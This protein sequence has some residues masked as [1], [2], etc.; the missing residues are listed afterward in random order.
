MLLGDLGADVLR[1]ESPTRNDLIHDIPPFVAGKSAAHL[2]LNRNKRSIALDL[3]KTEAVE[4]VH[5]L[6]QEYDILIEQF[7]P[8]VMAKLGLS[9]EELKV[10]KP[11]LIYC[12]VTGYGQTGPLRKKAGHDL[13][14]L[15]LSGVAS[16]SGRHKKGNEAGG[17][18]PHS[19]QIADIAGGSHH[20]IIGILAAVI[21]R[22]RTGKGQHIDISMVDCAFAM[23]GIAGAG[24]LASGT[25][26]EPEGGWLNGGSFYDYYETA[27]GRYMSVAGLEPKFVDGLAKT[28]GRPDLLELKSLHDIETQQR[29]RR[30]LA[31]EFQRQDFQHWRQLFEEAD[32]CVEPVLTINEAAAQPQLLERKAVIEYEHAEGVGGIAQSACPIRF[33]GSDQESPASAPNRGTNSVDVLRETGFDENQIA[34]FLDRQVVTTG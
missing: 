28:L 14:Y 25:D 5:R 18:V 4:V 26:P 22:A 21:H 27:D 11:D 24:A 29:L 6:V 16:Y 2:Y 31:D 12:S 15:A 10:S 19:L 9:Y 33:S 32:C 20:A 34:D 13:N 17:P 3:K 7:R 30:V 8:G 1:V 23:N